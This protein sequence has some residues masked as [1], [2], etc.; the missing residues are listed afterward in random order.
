ME[1]RNI[2]TGLPGGLLEKLHI[3][4]GRLIQDSL[5]VIL[6]LTAQLVL[7]LHSSV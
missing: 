6:P 2:D 4:G 7:N 1:Y 3:V 5:V